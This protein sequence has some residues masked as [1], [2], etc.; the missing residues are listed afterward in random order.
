MTE[1]KLH[2][3]LRK[4]HGRKREPGSQ[5]SETDSS[6]CSVLKGLSKQPHSKQTWSQRKKTTG[7][8]EEKSESDLEERYRRSILDLAI[9]QNHIALQCETIRKIQSERTNLGRHVRD[10]EQKLQWERGGSLYRQSMNQK[11]TFMH[12]E[13]TKKVA[14]LEK[15]TSQLK[16]ELVL[17]QE[18]L[19]KEKR[20]HV[21]VEQEK[22]AVIATL[23][24]SMETDCKR[25]LH[26]TL[27]GLT[28]QLAM[29]RQGWENKSTT[30]NQSDK[31]LLSEFG[32]T[33]QDI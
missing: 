22:E 1:R 25:A 16:G 12:T 7:K 5:C 13:L 10:M 27:D 33:T 11:M 6:L 24:D 14:R 21:Q 30:F 17:C 3:K 15:E 19:S 18:E 31:E 29:V 28:S 8:T 20:E 23:L 26:E 2:L 9:L 4:L 32:L